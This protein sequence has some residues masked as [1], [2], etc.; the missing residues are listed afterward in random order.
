MKTTVYKTYNINITLAR[1][2]HIHSNKLC[3]L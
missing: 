2:Y 3:Y 1:G